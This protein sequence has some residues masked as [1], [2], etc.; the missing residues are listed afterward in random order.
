MF[1]IS[2][3]LKL[4]NIILIINIIELLVFCVILKFVDFFE[5]KKV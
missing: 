3:V 4:F 1:M 2:R 5:K